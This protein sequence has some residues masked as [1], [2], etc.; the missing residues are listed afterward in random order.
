MNSRPKSQKMSDDENIQPVYDTPEHRIL[1]ISTSYTDFLRGITGSLPT[2]GRPQLPRNEQES[3][4]IRKAEAN[5]KMYE[6]E[7]RWVFLIGALLVVAISLQLL[8]IV[9][10][11]ERSAG[12]EEG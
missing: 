3:Y 11:M 7:W 1:K 8:I 9:L 2:Q 6:V 10:H 5:Q 4:R 12:R